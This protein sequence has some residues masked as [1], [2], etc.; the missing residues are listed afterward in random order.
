[1]LNEKYTDLENTQHDN[2]ILYSKLKKSNNIIFV[3]Y[4]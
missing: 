2:Y 1:M 3:T 4:K